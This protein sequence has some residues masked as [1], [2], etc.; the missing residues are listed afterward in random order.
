MIKLSVFQILQTSASDH[1]G[2]VLLQQ[3]LSRNQGEES[4][5]QSRVDLRL[6]EVQ[7]RG[8]FKTHTNEG[9]KR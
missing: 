8:L 3:T 2:P 7:M 4:K 5:A 1:L 9:R 6:G